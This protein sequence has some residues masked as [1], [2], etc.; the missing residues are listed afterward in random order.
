V[1]TWT[2]WYVLQTR[3]TAKAGGRNKITFGNN[4]EKNC[5]KARPAACS[6]CFENPLKHGC[7]GWTDWENLRQI[8]A[9]RAVNL[10]EDV[11]QEVVDRPPDS[12]MRSSA[13]DRDSRSRERSTSPRSSQ[14]ANRCILRRGHQPGRESLASDHTRS[15]CRQKVRSTEAEKSV[16]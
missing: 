15:R 16:F 2:T 10:V 5:K 6:T 12:I 4:R 8:S 9:I 14:G 3:P 1:Q 11:E 13:S 7:D